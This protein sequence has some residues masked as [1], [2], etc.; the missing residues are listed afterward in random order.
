MI[1]ACLT[2]LTASNA[3]GE[4]PFSVTPPEGRYIRQI[5]IA[6]PCYF[7]MTHKKKHPAMIRVDAHLDP[8]A[9]TP[10]RRTSKH[11]Q[12]TPGREHAVGH[13]REELCFCFGLSCTLG[14]WD[15]GLFRLKGGQLAEVVKIR[16]L[17]WGVTRDTFCV[18]L[19]KIK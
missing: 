6:M 2:Q 9:R 11:P 5:G 17:F 4:K 19:R 16:A 15:Q 10:S 8:L 18:A 1:F 7:E 14:G 12:H 13:R 3:K